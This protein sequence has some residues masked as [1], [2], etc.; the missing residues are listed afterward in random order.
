MFFVRRLR[1][2]CVRVQRRYLLHV[3]WAQLTRTYVLMY[4]RAVMY[5]WIGARAETRI[6]GYSARPCMFSGEYG[7]NGLTFA[8]CLH[9]AAEQTMPLGRKLCQPNAVLHLC[10]SIRDSC[11]ISMNVIFLWHLCAGCL[12]KKNPPQ[13]LL[14]L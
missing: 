8:P 9:T 14:Y 11:R 10:R 5:L 4:P 7:V 1:C 6:S 2:I 3:F 12:R 13:I